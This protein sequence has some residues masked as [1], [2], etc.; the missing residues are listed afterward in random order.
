M[1]S[2]VLKHCLVCAAAERREVRRRE[3]KLLEAA[4]EGYI[5]ALSELV[6]VRLVVHL[7]VNITLRSSFM[8]SEQNS[9]LHNTKKHTRNSR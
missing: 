8:I 2:L 9:L 7:S 4:R 3:E 6:S 1:A 5:S